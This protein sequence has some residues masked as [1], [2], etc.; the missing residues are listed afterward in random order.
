M[1]IG[2]VTLNVSDQDRAKEFYTKKLGWEVEDDAPMGENTRW[3]TVIPPGA[4]TSLVLAKGFGDWAPEKVG[5]NSG[6]A[7]EVDDVFTTAEK[8]KKNGVEFTAEPSNEFFGG[9]AMFKDSEG[10][11]LGMHSPAKVGATS[12]N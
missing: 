2:I 6:I 8:F 3:L 9:W 5:G 10:N 4:Q 7:L 12:Q 11:V 1:Y